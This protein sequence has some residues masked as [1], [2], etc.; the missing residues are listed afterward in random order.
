MIFLKHYQWWSSP[1][2]STINNLLFLGF[3]IFHN[4]A[5]IFRL[6]DYTLF[7]TTSLGPLLL[8]LCWVRFCTFRRDWMIYAPVEWLLLFVG[9]LSVDF[10]FK[11][12]PKT[13]NMLTCW[14]P[15]MGWASYRF[16]VFKGTTWELG[17][18]ASWL[19]LGVGKAGYWLPTAGTRVTL[20]FFSLKSG[21]NPTTTTT[22]MHHHQG[23]R[24]IQYLNWV[25]F[26]SM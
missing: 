23:W 26:T 14:V 22:T 7:G 16:C 17:C 13:V 11:R 5:N 12:R 20:L 15:A 8:R 6:I 1:A 19:L 10:L 24:K 18:D 4:L 2:F 3:M 21:F 9:W 25:R